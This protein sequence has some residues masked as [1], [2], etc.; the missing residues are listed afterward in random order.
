MT[1]A[2]QEKAIAKK[3]RQ[4][5]CHFERDLYSRRDV[6][7]IKRANLEL[8][9]THNND[10]PSISKTIL[11]EN[12]SK[13]VIWGVEK[14]EQIDLALD[15]RRKLFNHIKGTSRVVQFVGDC[16]LFTVAGTQFAKEMVE[17]Y[18][19]DPA[20][21]LTFGHSGLFK[22]GASDVNGILIDLVE[23]NAAH[24]RL[25]SN[26]VDQC[27]K[28]I[29]KWGFR[30]CR[31]TINHMVMVYNGNGVETRFGDDCD[32]SDKI[33]QKGDVLVLLEG[34][35]QSFLQALNALNQ[36]ATVFAL[37]GLREKDAAKFS[38][39]RFFNQVIQHPSD[40]IATHL[41]NEIMQQNA[42]PPHKKLLLDKAV[43]LLRTPSLRQKIRSVKVYQLELFE[44]NFFKCNNQFSRDLYKSF[45]IENRHKHENIQH[46]YDKHYG[47]T[48]LYGR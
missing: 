41:N 25:V 5:S 29:E 22:K 15:L 4:I 20:N 39:A 21:L 17:K 37:E 27:T 16:E 6:A 45:I 14:T 19:S 43:E 11:T 8:Q 7:A 46:E 48:L 32:I 33:M 28:A 31:S 10:T 42:W 12:D 1:P 47:L 9:T 23:R 30:T 26:V 13:Y 24:E 40:P 34:G 18:V 36:G 35:I 3:A 38:A 2:S 44:F